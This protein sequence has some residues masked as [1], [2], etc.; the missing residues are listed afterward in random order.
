MSGMSDVMKPDP[1]FFVPF[2]EMIDASIAAAELGDLTEAQ[3][4]AIVDAAVGVAEADDL[5]EAQVQTL[6]DASIAG[7]SSGMTE[8]QVQTMI[9]TALAG[10]S[11]G[12][13]EEDVQALIDA[14][15]A[16]IPPGGGDAVVIL[17]SKPTHASTRTNVVLG[18]LNN[19]WTQVVTTDAEHPDVK[20]EIEISAQLGADELLYVAL[21]CDGV[22][23]DRMSVYTAGAGNR[24]NRGSMGGSHTPAA[25]VHTYE[26]YFATGGSTVTVNS[27]V[28]VSTATGVNPNGVSSMQ[29]SVGN[30]PDVLGNIFM[31]IV[32]H[33]ADANVTRPDAPAVYWIGSVVP[34]NGEDFDLFYDTSA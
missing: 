21:V 19:P 29:L 1:S 8:E 17:K 23:V 28:D 20:Y 18:S 24:E 31:Q 6:I 15:I 22:I 3:V 32:N 34:V 10:F 33:G 14:S 5:T 16:A 27:V 26:V 2:Q 11:G 7:I 30:T 13:S 25:G 4:Q 9:D 12:L